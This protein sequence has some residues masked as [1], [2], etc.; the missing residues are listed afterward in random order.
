MTEQVRDLVNEHELDKF[1]QA[2]RDGKGVIVVDGKMTELLHL[3]Q[4]KQLV[5][6][7]AAIDSLA[8]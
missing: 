7:A 5:E 2:I 1:D 3:K 4:A 6:T 8:K